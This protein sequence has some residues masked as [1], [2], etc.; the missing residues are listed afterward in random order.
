MPSPSFNTP[1][2]PALDDV[3]SLLSSEPR[4]LVITSLLEG[5]T[6]SASLDELAD[7]VVDKQR[8]QRTR[9]Q[10]KIHLHHRD[11]PKL[12][13]TGVVTYDPDTHVVALQTPPAGTATDALT[14]LL[15][16]TSRAS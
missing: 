8:D 10:V 2:D 3:L 13:A 4:R 5:S 15:T 9:R 6:S 1:T 12:T 14:R 11:V 16:V 7:Y